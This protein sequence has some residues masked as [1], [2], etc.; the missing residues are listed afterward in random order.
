MDKQVMPEG[1]ETT[2]VG[3]T[4]GKF[5]ITAD[6]VSKHI[7]EKMKPDDVAAM[8]R[9]VNAGMK[10]LFSKETH[11]QIF[12]GIR[13]ADQVPIAD[14]LGAGATNIMLILFKESKN[15][16]PAQL[17]IPAGA[18]LLAKAC[19]FINETHLAVVTDDDYADA[20]QMFSASIVHSLD[21]SFK[22]KISGQQTQ[23]A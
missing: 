1:A 20:M 12:D 3:E 9:V 14:E 16:I 15:S 6:L 22:G 10:V 7:V 19:E 2:E 4:G 5:T 18:I 13:P 17:I 23:G 21:P 8:Q 11:S